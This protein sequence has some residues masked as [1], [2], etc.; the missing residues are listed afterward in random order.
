MSHGSSAT[1]TFKL[2]AKLSMPCNLCLPAPE[3]TRPP[4]S[5][6]HHRRSPF[7]P[8]PA[9]KRRARCSLPS[10]YWAVQRIA[11]PSPLPPIASH[12]LTGVAMPEVTSQQGSPSPPLCAWCVFA[13]KSQ[14]SGNALQWLLQT[15]PRLP[16]TARI[17]PTTPPAASPTPE[18][19]LAGP[20]STTRLE[21][22]CSACQH[23]A[24]LYPAWIEA[25]GVTL[26]HKL[27]GSRSPASRANRT[28]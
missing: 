23:P 26:T 21:S 11:H 16:R 14:T 5:P 19:G 28:G 4:A 8:R 22:L 10:Q 2:P 27:P 13:A 6:A 18:P 25:L 9:K 17:H 12:S 15:Q 20:P 1:H 7:A 3:S 24:R